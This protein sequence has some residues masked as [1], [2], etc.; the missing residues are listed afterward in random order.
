[1]VVSAAARV[2]GDAPRRPAEDEDEGHEIEH[3]AD[4]VGEQEDRPV[5]V[6]R[7]VAEFGQREQA[8][9]PAEEARA[10]P[11]ERQAK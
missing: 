3:F 9:P 1:M 7:H 4:G 8:E 11:K 5:E 6:V 10:R 2:G